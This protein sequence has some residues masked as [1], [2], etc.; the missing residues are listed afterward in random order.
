ME[1]NSKLS[2]FFLG[3]GVGVAIG[4]LFAP[5]S[6]EETRK[7]IREKADE[8]RNYAKKRSED[9]RTS[10]ADWVDK[11]KGAVA[12]QKDQISAAVEAGKQAYREAVSSPGEPGKS[13]S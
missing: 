7:Y 13:E 11:G 5:K 12:R 3:L 9:L 1:E 4:I 10:A 8:G 2:Y 6:G